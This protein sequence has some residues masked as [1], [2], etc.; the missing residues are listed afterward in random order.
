MQEDLVE[1]LAARDGAD[2]AGLGEQ[3][4]ARGASGRLVRARVVLGAEPRPVLG[5][6]IVDGEPRIGQLVLDLLAP[7]PVPSL[8]RALG[9]GVTGAG[10]NELD[11][12]VGAMSRSDWAM[13][14]GPRST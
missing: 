14:A 7:G 9:L 2:L 10:V 13:Y 11:A 8:D 12:E 3:V 4:L 1:I 5:R 6:E